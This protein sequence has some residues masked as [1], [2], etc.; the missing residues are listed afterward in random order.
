MNCFH[1]SRIKKYRCHKCIK[2]FE[3]P[4]DIGVCLTCF[5]GFIEEV[6]EEEEEEKHNNQ[7]PSQRIR[8]RHMEMETNIN[9]MV[10]H[11]DRL[12][13]GVRM[14][15]FERRMER[16]RE[17]ERERRRQNPIEMEF[18]NDSSSDN[19]DDP[20][21]I[22][23]NGN[24]VNVMFRRNNGQPS[25]VV[26]EN[27]NRIHLHM[28]HGSVPIQDLPNFL[29]TLMQNLGIHNNGRQQPATEETIENLNEI[30]ITNNHYE[31]DGQSGELTAPN[32]SI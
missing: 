22:G 6:N 16:V 15:P 7:Q 1:R 23:P 11:M 17:R 18:L 29:Q 4:D 28:P 13:Q 2:T 14:N 20:D 30:E 8:H 19:S 10:R 32:C 3:A 12:M 25:A 31:K 9:S 5:E 24:S 27:G 26:F 21:N